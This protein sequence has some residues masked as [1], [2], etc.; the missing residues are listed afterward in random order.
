MRRVIE[1]RTV[2]GCTRLIETGWPVDRIKVPYHLPLSA[3][4]TTEITRI[5]IDP[6]TG[7]VKAPDNMRCRIFRLGPGSGPNG[8]PVFHEEVESVPAIEVVEAA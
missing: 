1:L 7:R 5:P 3:V 8:E 6:M 4:A 2:C